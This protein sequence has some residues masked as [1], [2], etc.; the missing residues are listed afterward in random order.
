MPSAT[1]IESRDGQA[2][3][4]R[5]A[6]YGAG[7]VGQAGHAPSL[8]D[9]R[10]RFDLVAIVDPSATVRTAV[11]TRYGVPHACATL[12]DALQLGLDAVVIA[13]PDPAHRP[14]VLTAL[15]AGV[16]VFCE[17]PLA[18][19]LAECDEILAARGDRVVQV[20]Y[21]KLYDPAVERMIERLT[22]G[23]AELVYVSIEVNDPDQGPFVDHLGLVVGR[24]VPRSLIDETRRR[25]AEAV[26]EALGAE[27]DATQARAFEAYLS[28]LVHDVSLA[29]H[30]LRSIG[31]ASPLPIADAGYF[32]RGRG[33]TL[34]WT[35]PN[36]GRAHLEHLNLPGVAD[37][38][39]RI[40]AYCRDRILELTFPSPYLRHHP[41]RL[42]E[43]RSDGTVAG[44][45]TIDY[46]V[47]YEEAFRNEMRAFHAAI[48]TGVPVR[49]SVEAARDDLAA[50]LDG[51]RLAAARHQ[52]AS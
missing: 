10:D 24:D 16:H 41:T 12:E 52:A 39:E 6:L 2:T 23:P 43:R 40:T 28:S 51:F 34:D 13:V 32:D 30:L 44:L 14:A 1:T 26:R 5:V 20:G 9:D 8:W 18:V 47:S 17:K 21:M 19:S 22:D 45:E 15:R 46:R 29:H 35:L 11:A 37:Y 31:I 27:P 42:V 3:R 7:L 48:T 25:G 33:V 4:L 38:R 49:A 50:L 36:D